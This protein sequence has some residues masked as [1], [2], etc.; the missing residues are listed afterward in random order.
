MVAQKRQADLFGMRGGFEPAGKS[1]ISSRPSWL[2][3][4][5]SSSMS[6]GLTA[7]SPVNLVASKSR[8]W[9]TVSPYPPIVETVKAYQ[10]RSL[11]R[12]KLWQSRRTILLGGHAFGVYL[13]VLVYCC[14]GASTTH[15]PPAH[16]QPPKSDYAHCKQVY[17]KHET[18]GGRSTLST[19][20][21]I[22]PKKLAEQCDNGAGC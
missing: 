2:P 13:T 12:S 10:L 22:Q 18:P 6:S 21:S 1:S 16:C 17:P 8:P 14:V 3:C 19:Q 9:G 15:G 5:G 11:A 7:P 20:K 4:D